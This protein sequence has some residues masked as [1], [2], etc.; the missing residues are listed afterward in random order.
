MAQPSRSTPRDA[1]DWLLLGVGS[2][3]VVIA[4]PLAVAGA[5][6]TAA[7]FM[8]GVVMGL[9]GL[10][11]LSMRGGNP[12][13]LRD[14][15]VDPRFGRALIGISMLT[16]LTSSVM[17]LDRGDSLWAFLLPLAP[18]GCWVAVRTMRGVDRRP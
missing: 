11:D 14:S 12:R 6:A 2:L 16:V 18:L 17:V 9:L 1:V 13:V 5:S 10:V 7:V 15:L 8:T 4:V 3:L